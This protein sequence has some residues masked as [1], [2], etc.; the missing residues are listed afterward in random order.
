MLRFASSKPPTGA[1]TIVNNNKKSC[2]SYKD[3]YLSA[4]ERYNKRY[5]ITLYLSS[6]FFSILFQARFTFS[7]YTIVFSWSTLFFSLLLFFT[8]L[9]LSFIRNM[10]FTVFEPVYPSYLAEII[11]TWTSFDNWILF[12]I[13]SVLSLVIIRSYFY[14]ILNETYTSSFLIQPPG[15]YFGARQLNQENIFITLYC[16]ILAF[17]YTYHYL[18]EKS[19]IIKINNVQQP[20]QYEFKSSIAS[21]LYNSAKRAIYSFRNT[22][23]TFI[24]CNGSIYYYA[25]RFF[26]FYNKVLDSPIVGFRWIDLHL[27]LRLIMAGTV[28]MCVFKTAN[29]LYDAV[30]AITFPVT[31][32]YSNQFDCLIHGLSESKPN[33]QVAA[34]SELAVLACKYPEKR[35]EL[36][37]CIGKDLKDNAWYK[38]M[39]EC[40]KVI[41]ELR[42]K[43]D[44][45]Y[46][47]VQPVT[48][49]T[50]IDKPIQQ[51]QAYNRLEYSEGNIFA[52]QRKNFSRLD[53]RTG[54]IFSNVAEQAEEVSTS[55][56]PRAQMFTQ[57]KWE[58]ISQSQIIKML[59]EIEVQVGYVGYLKG[60]YGETVRRRIQ[61]VFNKYQLVIWA[62]QALGSL[63]ASSLKED[64]FGYVQNDLSHVLNTL[65]GCLVDIE[66]YLRSPPTKYSELVKEDMAV[67]EAHAVL[68]ALREA[69]F[70]I[71][72]AFSDYLEEFQID[73]KYKNAFI[74]L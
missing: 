41:D 27:F 59:K 29:R 63:A 54:A 64:P 4:M 43:I 53:D 23:V 42:A 66:R 24:I 73:R 57:K 38:I 13:H 60:I 56:I 19:Y 9:I 12:A 22:Y 17:N 3:A 62:V 7:F 21:I 55:T 68:R 72:I 10:M 16:I 74:E 58:A 40:I 26:G 5:L 34:F 32:A 48:P 18:A 47:G 31:N 71:K 8:G 61:S 6:L 39:T 49:P 52:T 30:Y 45:E 46:N 69:I 67:D 2:N 44:V 36:F 51:Q 37:R 25:A 70:Q 33:A 65:L 50:P 14:W 1:T 11:A 15:H 35:V 28:T 20:F